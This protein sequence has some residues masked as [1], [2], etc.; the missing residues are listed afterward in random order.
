MTTHPGQATMTVARSN[1]QR[2]GMRP[3]MFDG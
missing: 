3:P 2:P 1:A